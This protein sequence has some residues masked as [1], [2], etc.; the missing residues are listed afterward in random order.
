MSWFWLIAGPNGSGKTTLVQ[1]GIL[2]RALPLGR[3]AGQSDLVLVFDNSQIAQPVLV[4]TC[5]GGRWALLA[6]ERLPDLEPE[7]RRRAGV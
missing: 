1:R 6:P 2:H 5:T 7:L 3:F 4:A